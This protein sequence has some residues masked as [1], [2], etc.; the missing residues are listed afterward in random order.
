M[1]PINPTLFEQ[2]F[3]QNIDPWNYTTSPF[4]RCHTHLSNIGTDCLATDV[5]LL[6]HDGARGC[7]EYE[8]Q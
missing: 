8:T 5:S 6:C 1:K 4:E 2:K 7:D 3:R